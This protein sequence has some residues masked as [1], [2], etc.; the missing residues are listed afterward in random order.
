MN[1][2]I[3]AIGTP[4]GQPWFGRT[5]SLKFFDTS[6]NLMHEIYQDQ[7]NS[8]EGLRIKF[9]I[10]QMTYFI[11]QEA[12]IQVYN[13][14]PTTRK[15]ISKSQRVVL[16]AGYQLDS[17]ILYMGRVMNVYDNRIQPDYVL[18]FICLDFIPNYEPVSINIPAGTTPIDALKSVAA[19]IPDLAVNTVNLKNLPT[20]PITQKI[21][22]PQMEYTAAFSRLGQELGIDVWVLNGNLYSLPQKLKSF[23]D[24]ADTVEVDYLHGMIGSPFFDLANT[25]INVT[26]L[27]NPRLLPGNLVKVKTLNP[28]VQVGMAKYIK[29]DQDTLTRGTWIINSSQHTGD[30]RDGTWETFIQGYTYAPQGI[31]LV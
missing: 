17:G 19:L 24:E 12:M 6:G 14:S 10:K 3:K 20:A 23:P 2:N 29:F 27:L 28:Q 22:I 21:V 30:S 5:Y 31:S 4:K 11:N 1:P 16:T 18:T 13:L 15:L 7:R 25:G 9:D 8:W 26:S